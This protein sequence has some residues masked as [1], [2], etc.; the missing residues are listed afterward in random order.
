MVP[1]LPWKCRLLQSLG[2]NTKT[3]ATIYVYALF[4]TLSFFKT[5]DINGRKAKNDG[6]CYGI[7]WDNS[8]CRTSYAPG[9][10]PFLYTNV[11][12]VRVFHLFMSSF[13]STQL[14]VFYLFGNLHDARQR[15]GH[16]ALLTP[17]GLVPV[18]KG[19][20]DLWWNDY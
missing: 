18:S 15:K 8:N 14:C 9:F 12:K 13:S 6:V 20:T 16:D 10:P 11:F 7:I 2:I 3:I 5:F 4:E 19:T 1:L 17:G